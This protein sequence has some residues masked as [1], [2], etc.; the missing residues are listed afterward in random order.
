MSTSRYP[1]TAQQFASSPRFHWMS[2][3]TPRIH[4]TNWSPKP[5]S[6]FV[7]QWHCVKL[8]AYQAVANLLTQPKTWMCEFMMYFKSINKFVLHSTKRIL[9]RIFL[10]GGIT[11][12][13][14]INYELSWHMLGQL[15]ESN[16]KFKVVNWNIIFFI[17]G[18]VCQIT[19]TSLTFLRQCWTQVAF[20]IK[21]VFYC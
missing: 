18:H 6:S 7:P 16:S 1:R 15:W 8:K 10:K 12:S 9:F 5:S 21:W 13:S 14:H 11:T 3:G 19:I 17:S 2:K 4:T 20:E